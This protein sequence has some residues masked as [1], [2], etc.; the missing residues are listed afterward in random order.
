MIIVLI[1]S[2][3]RLNYIN[4]AVTHFHQL[5]AI[6]SPYAEDTEK[7]KY[8]SRFAQIQN[9]EDYSNLISELKSIALNNNQT[10]PKFDIW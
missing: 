8:L 9:K 6:V 1:I 10:V 2:S 5:Y 7:E 4:R 3:V